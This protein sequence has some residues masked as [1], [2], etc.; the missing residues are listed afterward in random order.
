MYLRT[1]GIVAVLLVLQIHSGNGAA[2]SSASITTCSATSLVVSVTRDAGMAGTPYAYGYKDDAGCA[3][4]GTGPFTVTYSTLTDCDISLSDGVYTTVIIVPK[5][6]T[7]IET[8]DDEILTITCNP[9]DAFSGSTSDG[10]GFTGDTSSNAAA[11]NDSSIAG[12]PTVTMTSALADGT[13]ISGAVNLGTSLSLTLSLTDDQSGAYGSFKGHTCYATPTSDSSDATQIALTDASGCASDTDF[14]GAFETSGSDIKATFP[15]FK[16]SNALTV[17]FHCSVV[18]CP[19]GDASSCAAGT[20]SGSDGGL[21]RKKRDAP[22]SR[23]RRQA[24]EPELTDKTL[25]RT[26]SLR[27]VIQEADDAHGNRHAIASENTLCL[28]SG[29][30]FAMGALIGLL[31]LVIVVAVVVQCIRRPKLNKGGDDEFNVNGGFH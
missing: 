27:V 18:V 4:T 21:G 20:C 5:L 15:A 10:T 26:T 30:I 11:G 12:D 14:F 9:A 29:I 6:S 22:E 31:F 3:V 7:G 1:T 13:A 8:S 23:A 17:Y 28:E 24:D 2:L 19:A 25:Q 16:F